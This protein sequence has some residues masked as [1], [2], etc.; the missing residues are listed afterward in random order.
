MLLRLW[1]QPTLTLWQDAWGCGTAQRLFC[2]LPACPPL[3]VLL[4][5]ESL[6]GEVASLKGR[7]PRQAEAGVSAELQEQLNQ[8]AANM[9]KRHTRVETAIYQVCVCLWRY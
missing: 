9:D 1:K 8:I 5:V 7:D 2:L 3:C 4:Q 6:S